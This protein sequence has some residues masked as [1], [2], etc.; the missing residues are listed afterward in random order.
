V[1][2]DQDNSED[3]DIPLAQAAPEASHTQANGRLK[4]G[5]FKKGFTGNAKGRPV[6]RERAWSSRQLDLDMLKE[7]NRLVEIQ[8]N[9]KTE[10]I[11]MSQLLNR[12]LLARAA[13]GDMKAFK[14]AF[15]KLDEA[16]SGHEY[17]NRVTFAYL[18]ECEL[19]AECP[20]MG[21]SKE[22]FQKDINVWRKRSR[23]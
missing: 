12:Q 10:L 17:R 22:E 18:E 20:P 19:E 11:T 23:R 16:Q 13:K 3:K 4:N 2:Q 21:L 5:R 8:V 7:A 15:E 1:S 9:G 14:L 6:K